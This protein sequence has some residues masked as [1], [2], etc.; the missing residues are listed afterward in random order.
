MI[1][2]FF[3]FTDGKKRR[4]RKICQYWTTI[5]KKAVFERFG[6]NIT[7]GKLPG[8]DECLEFLEENKDIIK[9]RAWDHV[10]DFVRNVHKKSINEKIKTRSEKAQN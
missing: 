10:K 3:Y 6:E 8:K 1:T 7:S 4:K 5:E 9:D 2:S